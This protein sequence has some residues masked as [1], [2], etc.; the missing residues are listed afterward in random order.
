MLGL[1]RVEYVFDYLIDLNRKCSIEKMSQWE[2]EQ[3][4]KALGWRVDKD[5]ERGRNKLL[6]MVKYF[7][8]MQEK[9]G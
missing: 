5:Y 6:S 3:V 1:K 8:L 9:S 7:N 2:I 4:L